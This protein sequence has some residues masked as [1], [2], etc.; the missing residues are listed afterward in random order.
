MNKIKLQKDNVCTQ[1]NNVTAVL[2]G[3]QGNL[4]IVFRDGSDIFVPKEEY[5]WW[6]VL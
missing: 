1:Y 4:T 2:C 5:D 3:T 6:C